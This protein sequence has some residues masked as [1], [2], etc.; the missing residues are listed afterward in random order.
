MKSHCPLRWLALGISVLLLG[1]GC[2]KRA[3]PVEEGTRNQIL[4][5]GN[6]SE[7]VDLDPHVTTSQQDFNLLLAL[8]E[9]LAVYDPQT[10][11]PTPGVAERWEVSS[12]NLTWT[13]HLRHNAKWSNGDPV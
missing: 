5:L 6:L 7:P 11:L 2:A 9:G 10:C 13:F 3:T 12:D 8:F 4:Q 1:A